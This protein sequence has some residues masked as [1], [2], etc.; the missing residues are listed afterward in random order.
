MAAVNVFIDGA[1]R[2]SLPVFDVEDAFSHSS[3]LKAI[4]FVFAPKRIKYGRF[5]VIAVKFAKI[6]ITALTV[7]TK[8]VIDVEDCILSFTPSETSITP[9]SA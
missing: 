7:P 3:A 8:P 4:A 6:K 2:V 9:V 5:K 1:K